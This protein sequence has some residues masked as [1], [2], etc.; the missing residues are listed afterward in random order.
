MGQ[1]QAD[2]VLPAEVGGEPEGGESVVAEALGEARVSLEQLPEPIDLAR[3]SG[4]EDIQLRPG[5]EQLAEHFVVPMIE[6]QENWCH[7]LVV[8]RAGEGRILL[9]GLLDPFRVPGADRFEELRD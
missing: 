3:G 2:R 4:L 5:G 6:S 8:A 1:Q 7:P 9:E